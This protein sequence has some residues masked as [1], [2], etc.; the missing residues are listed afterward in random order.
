MGNASS[1][2]PE[3]TKTEPEIQRQSKVT[4]NYFLAH[5]ATAP[6]SNCMGIQRSLIKSF[7]DPG[8]EKALNRHLT[9]IK[10]GKQQSTDGVTCP[11]LFILNINP[12]PKINNFSFIL[13]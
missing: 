8:L 1:V 5:P 10:P 13:S 7:S 2:N 6:V 12:H 4:F 11:S 3:E 9:A